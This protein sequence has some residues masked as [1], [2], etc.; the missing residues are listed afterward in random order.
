VP[1]AP[2]TVLAIAAATGAYLGPLPST[3]AHARLR[4]LL[5]ECPYEVMATAVRVG[6]RPAVVVFADELGDPVVATQRAE[7]L[8]TAAGEALS[9][10]VA[11]SKSGRRGAP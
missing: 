6:G 3:P 5:G 8:A 1:L 9:R 10:V 2:P 7:V 11:V 4:E